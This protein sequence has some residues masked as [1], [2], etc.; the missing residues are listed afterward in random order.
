MGI[1]HD[2]GMQA[3]TF[4]RLAQK[5]Q[6]S[7]MAVYRYYENKHALL[8][9]MLDRF[10]ADSNV[11]PDDTS[12][13]WQD[14]LSTVAQRMYQALIA[15]PTWLPYIG[16]L[17]LKNNGLKVLD[18]CLR[19]LDCEGFSQEQSTKAFFDLLQTLLGA[20]MAEQ[21]LNS[22]VDNLIKTLAN[23]PDQYPNIST[24][25]AEL[26]KILK[27]SQMD[28]GLKVLISGLEQNKIISD[29]SL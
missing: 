18:D 26:A 27:I 5:L 10:I 1:A 25:L 23:N 6:V 22:S 24:N 2:Q 16:Q 20:A 17:P 28:I 11:L 8:T 4:R 21:Q 9:A 29:Q 12:L 3:L 7:P 14:W 15:N 19:K 13:S